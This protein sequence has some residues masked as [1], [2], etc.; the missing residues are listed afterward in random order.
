[1]GP[2]VAVLNE[3]DGTSVHD[4][5]IKSKEYEAADAIR[6][7]L[8]AKGVVV[9]D[10]NKLWTL[11]PPKAQPPADT[12]FSLVPQGA[13]LEGQT[14]G[15]C[16]VSATGRCANKADARTSCCTFLDCPQRNQQVLFH[17]SLAHALAL[18]HSEWYE[19]QNWL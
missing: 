9:E 5:H 11:N 2:L 1:M 3:R 14:L 10:L 17:A 8:R 16:G 19:W 12:P 13:S 4:E 15:P 6:R 18:A 7:E